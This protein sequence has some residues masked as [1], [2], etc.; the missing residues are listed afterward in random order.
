MAAPNVMP[1][2]IATRRS[3]LKNQDHRNISYDEDIIVYSPQ[4]KTVA[5]AENLAV[6]ASRARQRPIEQLPSGEPT[7]RI[8]EAIKPTERH[9]IG[10][11][12]QT[13]GYENEA[14]NCESENATQGVPSTY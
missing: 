1:T 13:T 10:R 14:G 4:R 3:I 8:R 2:S 12:G 9:I 11:V 5:W 7:E 6:F